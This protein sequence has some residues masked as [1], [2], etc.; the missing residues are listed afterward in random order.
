MVTTNKNTTKKITQINI[1][2]DF[3]WSALSSFFNLY[4]KML[5][6]QLKFPRLF[7]KFVFVHFFD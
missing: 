1:M 2:M 3:K 4:Y 5:N 7:W 6:S